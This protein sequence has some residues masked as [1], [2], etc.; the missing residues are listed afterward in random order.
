MPFVFERTTHGRII[1]WSTSASTL[2]QEIRRSERYGQNGYGR[3]YCTRYILIVECRRSSRLS[4]RLASV[5]CSLMSLL[6]AVSS[7]R[8]KICQEDEK[9]LPHILSFRG[10][11][12]RS[13]REVLPA[14]ILPHF[15]RNISAKLKSDVSLCESK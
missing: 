2:K 14:T 13:M 1:I 3:W 6:F 7:C 8:D 4:D 15:S 11:L 10:S 9:R 12:R 5:L